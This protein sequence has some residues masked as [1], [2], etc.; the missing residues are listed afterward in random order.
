MF[1][2][3]KKKVW[4]DLLESTQF[5]IDMLHAKIK[6]N[7]RYISEY[8]E[9]LNR[10]T[11]EA[12]LKHREQLMNELPLLYDNLENRENFMKVLKRG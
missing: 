3:I 10:A 6:T 12:Y 4:N 1:K 2:I 7:E 9:S 5:E 8:T 11:D